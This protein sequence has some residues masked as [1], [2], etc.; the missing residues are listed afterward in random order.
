M[1]YAQRSRGYSTRR[2][3]LPDEL[4]RLSEFVHSL[5]K[6]IIVMVD[7]CYGEF[8]CEH[9]PPYF[10]VDLIAGSLIKNPG[11]GLAPTGGYIAG[12]A[13]LVELASQRLTAPGIGREIGSYEPGLRLFYQGLYLAPHIVSEAMKG[14][15]LIAHAFE[16]LGFHVSPAWDESIKKRSDIVQSIRL[17]KP[18]LVEAFCVA[19]QASSPVD[20]FVTPESWTMPGYAD[21]V[22]M[23]AGT[24]VSGSSIEFSADAPLREPYDV[25]MQGGLTSQQGHIFLE[26][27]L[28]SVSR[29]TFK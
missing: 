24:F 28:N 13:D 15:I 17:G 2:S 14:V 26:H 12:R 16:R 4:G 29:F 27:F 19:V 5:N 8:V 21:K 1:V 3:I 25:F 6:D 10:G 20:S 7:N 22:I 23:A 18:E 11:G 9:E